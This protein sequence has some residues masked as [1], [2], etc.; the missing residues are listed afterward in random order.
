MQLRNYVPGGLCALL[1]ISAGWTTGCGSDS[2]NFN[3]VILQTVTA[4]VSSGT[5]T[6]VANGTTYT[7]T[8]ASTVT[9]G[10]TTTLD[11]ITVTATP[12]TSTPTTTVT[13]SPTVSATTT[14]TTVTQ[15][16]TT[17]AVALPTVTY[18][19]NGPSVATT[20]TP[21][22]LLNGV[23]VDFPATGS[24]EGGYLVITFRAGENSDPLPTLNASQNAE[25]GQ[26]FFSEDRNTLV[27]YFDGST[28][29]N[30]LL[31]LLNTVTGTV[32][33][34]SNSPQSYSY[35]TTVSSPSNPGT[36]NNNRNLD[37]G[38]AVPL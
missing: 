29:A 2:D 36:A 32:A 37:F 26:L 38:F 27:V 9:Q 25:S 20:N 35:T 16:A 11:G 15:S 10:V 6:V 17:T 14:T 7:V 13:T 23:T 33:T 3:G 19:T 22:A 28:T 30:G 31:T 5:T 24:V 1:L 21:V 18:D 34:G 8:S 4:T 12:T